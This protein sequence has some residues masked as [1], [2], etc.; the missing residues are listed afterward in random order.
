MQASGRRH[1]ATI[2]V[3]NLANGD[4]GAIVFRSDEECFP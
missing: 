4:Y 2:D 1:D 3:G